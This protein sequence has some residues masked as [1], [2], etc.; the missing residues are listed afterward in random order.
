MRGNFRVN[1]L[2]NY[3]VKTTSD[4]DSGRYV[5]LKKY[6]MI[7]SRDNAHLDLGQSYELMV[8]SAKILCVFYVFSRPFSEVSSTTPI[9]SKTFST[10]KGPM[11]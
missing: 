2:G 10:E 3:C 7:V 9:M 5:K 6:P 8:T 1:T 4:L 11:D